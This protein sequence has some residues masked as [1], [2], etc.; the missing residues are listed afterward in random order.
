LVLLFLNG[1]LQKY[2]GK[3]LFMNMM[4]PIWI[5]GGE[6]MSFMKKWLKATWKIKYIIKWAY[7]IAGGNIFLCEYARQYNPSVFLIPTVVDTTL[8]HFKQRGSKGGK[9]NCCRL[10]RHTY[11]TA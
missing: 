6:N 9:Q 3:K 10:D 8:S 7:K 4:M 11:N 2:F 5:P 1:F